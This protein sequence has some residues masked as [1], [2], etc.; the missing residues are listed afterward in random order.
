MGGVPTRSRLSD[1]QVAAVARHHFGLSPLVPSLPESA[2][3]EDAQG[4]L[5]ATHEDGQL[6]VADIARWQSPDDVARSLA[7]RGWSAPAAWVGS[8]PTDT[9]ELP[10]RVLALLPAAG[11]SSDSAAISAA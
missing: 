6:R 11:A 2:E 1:V 7:E 9:S 4:V 8:P 3:F 10:A 5:V